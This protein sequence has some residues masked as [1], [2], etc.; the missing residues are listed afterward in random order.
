MKHWTSLASVFLLLL[1]GCSKDQ[2]IPGDHGAI[3]AIQNKTFF[4][5]LGKLNPY[6][7]NSP[8]VD[9]MQECVYADTAEESC[10]VGDLPLIGL[11]KVNITV[12]DILDRT[13]VSH[14][15]LGVTFKEVLSRMNP[16][17]LQMFGAVTAIVISD[18]VNPSFY[19]SVS[20]AI[21]LS[22]RYFWK[23]AKERKL[24]TQVKDFRE[25]AGSP[26]QFFFDS[27]YLKAGKSIT[28]RAVKNEQS[29]D[30]M[31][32]NVSR[33][34]FHELSHAND[35]FPKSFYY[36]Q[37]LNLTKTYQKTARERFLK[38][39]LESDK[40]PSQVT[41][42]KLIH[43]GQVLY[44]GKKATTE[45]SALLAEEVIQEFKNDVASD[46][47]AYST[48]R[49]DYAMIAE[50]ALMLYYYETP[51][52]LFVIKLPE[53]NFVPPDDYVYQIAWG[54]KS[55]VLE[56]KIKLRAA[57]VVENDLGKDVGKKIIEKLNQYSSVEIPANL[58]WKEIIKL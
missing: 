13:L 53:A 1:V 16:E 46:D 35:Y 58:T 43:I 55:R 37:R 50:E 2:S 19:Y 10:I 17:M 15:F 14:D 48:S 33:L 20:G 51:R 31:A 56:P 11:S 4:E 27:E 57:I 26:L 52:F 39:E 47:Y 25:G 5:E 54:E 18:K 41:S 22:G 3:S 36:S 32:I 45:D 42:Q 44:Q 29:Y 49:E 8:Y 30:E 6:N 28:N 7:P 9:K 21:Y 23:N 12:E 34:L 38:K 40:L 24:L